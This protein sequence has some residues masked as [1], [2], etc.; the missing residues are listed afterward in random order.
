ME[1]GLLSSSLLPPPLPTL[2]R[3]QS[4]PASPPR[5]RHHTAGAQSSPASPPRPRHHTPGRPEQHIPSHLRADGS[6]SVSRAPLR[7]EPRAS[8]VCC[9]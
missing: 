7:M 5:P 3:A 2:L 4:G 1:V 6:S 9:E 8:R